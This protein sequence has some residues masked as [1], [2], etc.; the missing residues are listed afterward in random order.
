MRNGP[1]I[2]TVATIVIIKVV[3][4]SAARV[5]CIVLTETVARIS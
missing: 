2:E 5:A 1:L 3:D 4:R